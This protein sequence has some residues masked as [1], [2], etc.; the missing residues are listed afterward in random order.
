LV[1]CMTYWHVARTV[2]L[3]NGS[4]V[5][6]DYVRHLREFIEFLRPVNLTV[7]VRQSILPALVMISSMARNGESTRKSMV[8][9]GDRSDVR[10]GRTAVCELVLSKRLDAFERR[11]IDTVQGSP[12][13]EGRSVYRGLVPVVFVE[14]GLSHSVT[15]HPDFIFCIAVG[16]TEAADTRPRFYDEFS[17]VLD[18]PGECYLKTV[19][20]AFQEMGHPWRV[21]GD[22]VRRQVITDIALPS[23]EVERHLQPGL[24]P[25]RTR[26]LHQH[27][28][29]A[30]ALRKRRLLQ[31]L[32]YFFGARAGRRDQSTNPQRDPSIRAVRARAAQA[33]KESWH[34][35]AKRLCD[36]TRSK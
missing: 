23:L 32:R 31:S 16:G 36:A 10:R 8:P 24:D 20:V 5:L 22:A 1:G 25:R 6:G 35:P 21:W 34:M 27:R 19:R 26:P 29:V 3:A 2:S 18:R 13:S 17:A 30:H 7:S 9:T 12:L 15:S 28:F 33:P 14:M 4:F 11:R